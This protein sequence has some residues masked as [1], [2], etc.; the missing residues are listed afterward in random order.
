MTTEAAED[1]RKNFGYNR[2]KAGETKSILRKFVANVFGGF[3]I[4]LWT[5]A[6]LCLMAYILR[7]SS[8][9]NTPAG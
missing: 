2:L 7:A 3:G 1:A 9:E 8:V 4:I 5:G 6:I